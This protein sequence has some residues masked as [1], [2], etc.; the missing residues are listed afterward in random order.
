MNRALLILIAAL[1]VGAAVLWATWFIPDGPL[2]YLAV[3]GAAATAYMALNVG[4]NDVANNV[5]PAVGAKAITMGSA[6]ALAAVFEIC[7]AL[8]AGNEVI[9]TVSRDLLVW[10]HQ[11]AD[12]TLMLA[13]IAALLAAAL[14]INIS[15]LFGA[16]VSTTHAIVGGIVGAFAAAAGLNAVAWPVVGAIA[17]T[18]TL[19]PILGGILAAAIHAVIRKLITRRIDKIGAARLWVP[20]LVAAMAGVFAAYLSTK[21]HPQGWRPDVYTIAA[22]SLATAALGWI[23]AMPWVRMN[24]L[25][26]ENRKK[27]VGRL[28]R[29]PLIV[30]AALLSFAHG[31]NDVANA[32]GPFMTILT[33]FSASTRPIMGDIAP[34]W[35]LAIGAFG[36]ACGLALFGPRVIHTIGEQITKLNEIRAFCVALSAA[37]TVLLASAFGLPVSSTHVAVGAVFGVGFLREYLAMRNMQGAAAI[38]TRFLDP[39]SLNATPEEAIARERRHDRRYLVRRL[40]VARIAAAWVITLP[41]ATAMGALLYWLA[42]RII[43]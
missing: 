2:R 37:G 25:T 12:R 8:F 27:Q 28:F 26:M 41:A 17:V 24:S 35:T 19:S 13:M 5:G 36:I 43:G 40:K 34:L 16:P 18:W 31:S 1:F 15:T 30:A 6:L 22:I 11:F 20:L 38:N 42:S 23:V 29:P 9:T 14:W 10:N 4:A 32:V 39:A 7:G 33:A 3:I 21:L